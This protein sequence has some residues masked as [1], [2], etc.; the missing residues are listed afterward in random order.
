MKTVKK[1]LTQLLTPRVVNHIDIIKLLY[2]TL[3]H[4][5]AHQSYYVRACVSELQ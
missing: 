3:L 5:W 4:V 1:V 2:D